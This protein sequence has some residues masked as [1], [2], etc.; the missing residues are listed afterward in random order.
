MTE[1]ESRHTHISM[2]QRLLEQR[3]HFAYVMQDSPSAGNTDIHSV[4]GRY[5]SGNTRH[6]FQMRNQWQ[7]ATVLMLG[8]YVPII[9]HNYKTETPSIS[10]QPYMGWPLKRL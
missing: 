3:T 8:Q 2:L 6:T 1:Y 4:L 9:I 7:S 10:N 5:P